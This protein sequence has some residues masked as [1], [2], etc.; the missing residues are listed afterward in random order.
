MNIIKEIEITNFP[1]NN[2]PIVRVFND[3]TSYL[4]IDNVEKFFTQN[5]DETLSKLLQVEVEQEDRERFIIMTNDL[6][7]IEQLK[8]YLE[9]YEL[10]TLNEGKWLKAK[11]IDNIIYDKLG[12]FLKE[13]NSGFKQIKKRRGFV[14]KINGIA[15]YLSFFYTDYGTFNYDFILGI[16]IQ[17]VHDI[18]NKVENRE[19]YIGK[20]D[21]YTCIL[22]FTFFTNDDIQWNKEWKDIAYAEEVDNMINEVQQYYVKYIED[23]IAKN[24]TYEKIV[25]LLNTQ[26]DTNIFYGFASATSRFQ[27]CITLMKLMKSEKYSE[28]VIELRNL[29]TKIED[30]ESVKEFDKVV[31][32]LNKNAT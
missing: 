32:Y 15:F 11:E 10:D 2:T 16:H 6:D 20:F 23:F 17:E 12:Y 1:E 22:P 24:S 26:I 21:S 13:Q 19:E 31:E 5:L 9:N 29:L 3:G 18:I 14:K 27:E 25:K 7:K 4:L 8:V 28:R 30:K